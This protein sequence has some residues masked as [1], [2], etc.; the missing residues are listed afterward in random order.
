MSDIFGNNQDN[1]EVPENLKELLVGETGKYKTEDEALKGLYHAN[2][3]I[4]NLE[5]QI[6]EQAEDLQKRATVEQLMERIATTKN[7]SS[8]S[9]VTP[10]T[11]GANPAA[12]DV[13][14][15]E[16]LVRKAASEVVSTKEAERTQQANIKEVADAMVTAHGSPDAAR[17]I[18]AERAAAAGL[19]VEELNSLVATKPVAAKTILGLTG[20][21]GSP[22]T[23]AKPS[24]I[25][26][27]Q[28]PA[29]KDKGYGSDEY[30]ANLRR[31]N[32]SLYYSPKMQAEMLSTKMARRKAT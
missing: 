11:G 1:N 15:I 17:R 4:E 30:W 20:S 13:G 7:T 8:E 12:I 14:A 16:E 22:G 18:Y 32:P 9:S 19:T 5:R 23:K 26:G 2:K 6:R 28:N 27:S 3:H 25:N 21:S 24:I 29:N 10:P 31:T